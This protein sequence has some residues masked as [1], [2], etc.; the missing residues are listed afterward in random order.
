MSNNGSEL[1]FSIDYIIAP[2]CTATPSSNLFQRNGPTLWTLY[3]FNYTATT[4]AP[5][6]V[7]AFSSGLVDSNY[8]DDVSVVDKSAPSIQLL[9]NP[10]FENSTS[11]LTG[12]ATWCT[13]GCGSSNA[14]QVTRSLCNTNNCYVD[15]C[16]T[17]YDYLI[18]SFSATVGHTYTI[19]FRL[20]QLTLGTVSKFY[21]SIQA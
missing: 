16:Q 19:S 4:T 13:S 14:G 5:T 15:H 17:V 9:D 12:W 6:L 21:A 2:S 10:S 1:F 20:Q 18:Q 8:L 3:S 11:T 7:F